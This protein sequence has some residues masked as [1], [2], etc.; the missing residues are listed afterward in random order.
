M[1]VA[2]QYTP[3]VLRTADA[4]TDTICRDRR[5]GC[6]RPFERSQSPVPAAPGF[7]N[8]AALAGAALLESKAI[9][10]TSAIVKTPTMAIRGRSFGAS[11]R[12]PFQPKGKTCSTEG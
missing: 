8:E 7:R 9:M 1:C 4:M 12:V 10:K 3:P 5:R 2:I 6:A 11:A